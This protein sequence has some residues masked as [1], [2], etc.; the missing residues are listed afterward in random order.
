MLHSML[1]VQSRMTAEIS[2][3]L[4]A[5]AR[6]TRKQRNRNVAAKDARRE[7]GKETERDYAL[8][9]I[10]NGVQ[11]AATS[12]W[13]RGGAVAELNT[14]AF[15]V[16]LRSVGA[17]F[18]SNLS[19]QVQFTGLQLFVLRLAGDADGAVGSGG[20]GGGGSGG[21]GGDADAQVVL[22]LRT[23]VRLMNENVE[24]SR[25]HSFAVRVTNTGIKLLPGALRLVSQMQRQYQ[26][27]MHR[28]TAVR[29]EVRELRRLD[30]IGRRVWEEVKDPLTSQLESV[31]MQLLQSETV[32]RVT[33][34]LRVERTSVL[35][36]Y[37]AVA[38]NRT[39]ESCSFLTTLDEVHVLMYS[40]NLVRRYLD[41]K[42]HRQTMIK[43]HAVLRDLLISAIPPA[44]TSTFLSRETWRKVCHSRINQAHLPE[45]QLSCF[46]REG[47]SVQQAF[48]E[49]SIQPV[50]LHVN[51]DILSHVTYLARTWRNPAAWSVR[52]YDTED[53]ERR[54]TGETR[55]KKAL[56]LDVKVNV[57][58]GSAALYSRSV[59]V[60]SSRARKARRPSMFVVD[61][62]VADGGGSEQLRASY[63]LPLPE[64]KVQA[65]VVVDE[66]S[67][68]LLPNC[69]DI[70]V[71]LPPVFTV[72][73]NLLALIGEMQQQT[74]RLT[75][76]RGERT[77]LGG[78]A[79]GS[80]T[81]DSSAADSSLAVSHP[82]VVTV[83]SSPLLVV[84]AL[85]DDAASLRVVGAS[86]CWSMGAMEHEELERVRLMCITCSVHELVV[87]V[88]DPRPFLEARVEGVVVH[89]NAAHGLRED[90]AA[91][92]TLLGELVDV[93][94]EV[95]VEMLERFT[96]LMRLVQDDI[97][98][99]AGGPDRLLPSG[100]SADWDST[101]AA[102][103]LFSRFD[104]RRLRVGIDCEDLVGDSFV[105]ALTDI[106]TWFVEP[107]HGR[108]LRRLD[109]VVV[110]AVVKDIELGILGRL[111]GEAHVAGMA[112]MGIRQYNKLPAGMSSALNH[113][114]LRVSPW[115][116][117]IGHK[118][119][120]VELL[121]VSGNALGARL[122]DAL[123][124]DVVV[125][126]FIYS[127]E[128]L[129][130]LTSETLPTL[131]KLGAAIGSHVSRVMDDREAK[132]AEQLRSSAVSTRRPAEGEAWI[133]LDRLTVVLYDSNMLEGHTPE[134]DLHR[135]RLQLQQSTLKHAR[136]PHI[137]RVVFVDL[138]KGAVHKADYREEGHVR[139]RV[140]LGFPRSA[141]EMATKQR[142]RSRLLDY[143][144]RTEFE[145][146]IRVST[147]MRD[148]RSLNS[149]VESYSL[150][151][152]EATAAVRHAPSGAMGVMAGF[153][154]AEEAPLKF[155]LD[156]TEEDAYVLEPRL[157]VLGDWTPSVE[158]V[159][160]NIGVPESAVPSITYQASTQ[161]IS[162]L[163]DGVQQLSE[164][165][166]ELAGD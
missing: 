119:S 83:S 84:L 44:E 148:Y 107:G 164:A 23:N 12:H 90:G 24:S 34:R 124:E 157:N 7:E 152:E 43:G 159:L 15:H 104:V 80:R 6:Y 96:R 18:G 94:V 93:A 28:Y 27:A 103:T 165:M 74:T 141:L 115:A 52:L 26:T 116:L 2:T 62:S 50:E 79:A 127:D 49:M 97:D 117:E 99:G 70:A 82:L 105:L 126:V 59:G 108:G 100:S 58:A 56:Q 19:W 13:P 54:P 146:S 95:H 137:S 3:F 5:V 17:S 55:R 144:F 91:F 69:V 149:I 32:S 4:E 68:A 140:V 29:S 123:G 71:E 37:T 38:S 106:S 156:T 142:L 88:N 39:T 8:H 25:D 35:V 134:I 166:D 122:R 113:A 42:G 133:R 131:S 112:F 147:D 73:S 41:E 11:L 75:R 81:V 30:R 33:V 163:L 78:K 21:D 36:P 143:T 118:L 89:Y 129:A 22:N 111:E 125:Q 72:D 110:G 121:Q 61:G 92:C 153:E 151:M 64:V 57:Q 161:P 48:A 46:V 139:R 114:E 76:T 31:R 160:N 85:E 63:V 47:E 77:R 45:L 66:A 145:S 53:E 51:A 60:R 16:A 128:V 86:L 135:L 150:R 120:Q 20:G 132:A 154:Q 130:K 40:T 98:G 109:N 67:D 101:R 102:S 10:L 155:R 9:F 136:K 65:A 138:L 1:A 162:A 158:W 87:T 14:G